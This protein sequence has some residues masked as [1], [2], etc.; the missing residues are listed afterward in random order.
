M[1]KTVWVPPPAWAAMYGTKQ[2]RP[3]E[4]AFGGNGIAV[5]EMRDEAVGVAYER[6]HRGVQEVAVHAVGHA[7]AG[8]LASLGIEPGREGL[9]LVAQRVVLG[10]DDQRARH[11][12]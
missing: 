3:W 5:E 7:E 10:G 8:H 11:V 6:E 12:G 4:L 1:R 2:G 9:A